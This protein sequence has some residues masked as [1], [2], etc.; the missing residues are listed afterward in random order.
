MTQMTAD[1]VVIGGGVIGTSIAMHL[2]LRGAGRVILLERGHLAGGASGLS[3]AMVREH[4]L[5][6]VLVRMAME[7]SA[8]FQN[9]ADA[10]GG[11][12]GFRRTGRLLLFPEHD[13]AAVRA[14]VEMNRNLGVNIDILSPPEAVDMIPNLDPTG[15]DICA[16]EPEAGYA[17]PVATTYAYANRA[18]AHGAQIITE[19]TVTG[20]TV[21]R[22]RITGVETASG[23]VATPTVVVAPGS[24]TNR[25]AGLG[26]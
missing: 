26:G 18:R 3:G 10:V 13:S 16:Y 11:D 8:V 25:L 7:S 22:G 9:F 17:D 12:A 1:A 21:S 2:A 15:I 20:L 6:P 14:N 5:H 19:T 24:L 4:Y 23:A